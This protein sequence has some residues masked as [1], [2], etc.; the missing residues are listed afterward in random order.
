MGRQRWCVQAVDVRL[1]LPGRAVALDELGIIPYP[2]CLRRPRVLVCMY[3]EQG[4]TQELRS[5]RVSRKS[6]AGY[7]ELIGARA[8]GRG[9]SIGS[10]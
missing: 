2:A 10:R 9:F 7:L 5:L 8:Q 4:A 3:L 1:S 6:I